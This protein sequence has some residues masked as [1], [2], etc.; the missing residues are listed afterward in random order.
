MSPHPIRS[1]DI[2]DQ[3]KFRLGL[4]SAIGI[5]ATIIGCSIG[6]AWKVCS[7]LDAIQGGQQ[8]IA[9]DIK[10]TRDSLQY[11]VSNA[12][13]A[14][15]ASQLDHMNRGVQQKDGSLGL[16]VPAP[17]GSVQQPQLMP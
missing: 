6:G 15:W 17:V 2:S 10:A 4:F 14:S 13:F 3:S 8:Q 12:Q 1:L 5:V 7:Y 11:K 9:A 16:F